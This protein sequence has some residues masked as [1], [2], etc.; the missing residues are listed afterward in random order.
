MIMY[1]TRR[2]IPIVY[3]VWH[4]DRVG[5]FLSI[6]VLHG[7]FLFFTAGEGRD[8]NFFG[9]PQKNVINSFIALCDLDALFSWK[10][11]E[12]KLQ[13]LEEMKEIPGTVLFFSG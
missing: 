10:D 11:K 3:R 12:Q 1:F 7:L 13:M 6:D 4:L 2:S 5:N 8:R 9:R